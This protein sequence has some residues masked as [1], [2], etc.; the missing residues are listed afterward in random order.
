M[1]ERR[2]IRRK[3]KKEIGTKVEW[4]EWIKI[5]VCVCVCVCK[6]MC[7]WCEIEKERK[8]KIMRVGEFCMCV[9]GVYGV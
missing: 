9:Y 2:M 3:R 4:I 7:V 6:W 8:W 1:C 5:H